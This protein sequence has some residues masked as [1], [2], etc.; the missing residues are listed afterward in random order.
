MQGCLKHFGKKWLIMLVIWLINHRLRVIDFKCAEEVWSGKPV[1]YSNLRV[2]SCSAYAHIPSDARTK[3]KPKSL[4]C[5]LIGFEKGV[6]GN[7]LWDIVNKKKMISRD[8]VFNEMT[9][10]LNEEI[11]SKKENMTD[12]EEEAIEILLAN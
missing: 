1:D 2:F 6:K 3:L 7:K 11:N 5:L 8:I 9:M 10:P 12:I 4:E